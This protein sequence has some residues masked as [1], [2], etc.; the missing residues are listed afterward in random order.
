ML[1][2]KWLQQALVS[3]LVP[4]HKISTQDR[5]RAALLL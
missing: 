4:Q 5:K 1:S 3:N 2:L